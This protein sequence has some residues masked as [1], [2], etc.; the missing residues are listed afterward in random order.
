MDK[1]IQ[2]ILGVILNL[3]SH[4][5]LYVPMISLISA[6]IFLP[7]WYL[8]FTKVEKLIK[9]IFFFNYIIYT[10]NIGYIVYALLFASVHVTS[11]YLV[12]ASFAIVSLLTLGRP[13]VQSA[14]ATIVLA[15]ITLKYTDL[16]TIL[17]SNTIAIALLFVLIVFILQALKNTITL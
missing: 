9:T 3:I 11:I 16:A 4:L 15:L 17:D 10:M 5:I 14:I 2:N 8:A 6:L 12:L 13:I 7:S 1:L